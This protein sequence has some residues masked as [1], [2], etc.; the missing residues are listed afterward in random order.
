VAHINFLYPEQVIK[1]LENKEKPFFE[2]TEKD[3]WLAFYD[4]TVPEGY[5]IH[6]NKETGEKLPNCCETHRSLFKETQDWF[7]KFPMDCEPHKK[8][9]KEAWF[10]RE[11]YKDVAMKVVLQF[12]YTT[13]HIMRHLNTPDWYKEANDY[14]E[15]LVYSFG[16]FPPGYGPSVGLDFY[17]TRLRKWVKQETTNI[18]AEKKELLIKRID[19][20]E[21]NSPV[22]GPRKNTTRD[23]NILHATFQ[24]WLKLFPF[25]ILYFSQLKE[26]LSKAI[27]FLTEPPTINKYTGLAQTK[28]HTE[29]SLIGCLHGLTLQL[30]RQVNTNELLEKGIISDKNKHAIEVINA[31]HKLKQ[32]TVLLKFTKGE[33]KYVKVLKA[34]LANEKE[35]FKELLPM[36]QQTATAV[37]S[38]KVLTRDEY[39]QIIMEIYNLHNNTIDIYLTDKYKEYLP[40]NPEFVE[41]LLKDIHKVSEG[42]NKPGDND[43][44][45]ENGDFAIE[46]GDIKR[47]GNGVS[48]L[49]FAE[50]WLWIEYIKKYTD[51]NLNIED[52]LAHFENEFLT[53]NDYTPAYAKKIADLNK[54]LKNVNTPLKKNG[55]KQT[56]SNPDIKLSDIC[57]TKKA[58]KVIMDWLIDKGYCHS[59][60]FKWKDSGKGNKGVLIAILK[61]LWAKGYYKKGIVPSHEDYRNIAKNTFDWEVAIDTIKKT[62]SQYFLIDFL[63]VY[64]DK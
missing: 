43:I 41:C 3:Y 55:G 6:E 39:F 24:K 53:R 64:S 28:M 5:T 11:I 32:D 56:G 34:W 26:L 46:H 1:A 54:E 51:A 21:D 58:Y 9:L 29:D 36:I 7:D 19:R 40:K 50:A 37:N 2:V 48:N 20:F 52:F 38:G 22:V 10:N 60:T 33:L 17:L 23:L 59:E 35:Y 12:S 8:L 42:V 14:M 57:I 25:D 15:H 45:I 30:L 63:P 27:L 16:Q 31:N 62:K 4:V 18:P 49:E 13:Y 44:L 61:D 47:T